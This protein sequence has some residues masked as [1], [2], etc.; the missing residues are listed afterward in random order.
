VSERS[1]RERGI[2]FSG[3]MIRALLAGKTQT[4]R[5][6]KLSD[7]TQTY[8]CFDDDGWP[9]SA[10]DCGDWTRDP[11]PYGQ[12]GD[13]LYVK[14]EMRPVTLAGV[15]SR[16]A[17]YSA[18]LGAPPPGKT[19]LVHVCNSCVEWRWKRDR[20]PG[21]FM[22]RE[23]SRITLE[24]VSVRVQ[25]VQDITEEDAVAEVGDECNQGECRPMLG[26][27]LINQRTIT[28]SATG[29]MCTISHEIPARDLF[30]GVW[31]CINESRGLGWAVNPRVWAITFRRK[32]L[33][34]CAN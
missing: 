30:S 7:P 6:V 33:S 12:P 5:V 10:D 13:S 25:R 28:P 11:C 16:W 29:F 34:A 31:D 17:A 15:D 2:I 3:P 21:M 23:C 8:A 9:M 4:R 1:Q 32:E 24:V 22:P 26:A 18:T 14:E 27:P 19:T 20:L